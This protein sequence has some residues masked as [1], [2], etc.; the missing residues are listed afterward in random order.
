MIFGSAFISGLVLTYAVIWVTRKYGWVYVPTVNRWS[1]RVVSLHGGIAIALSFL[2]AHLFI[3]DLSYTST[4]FWL[5][6]L[7][8]VML[9][10][11]FLDDL[12]GLM[13]LPKLIVQFLV[14][15]A[16]F[17][18][19]L[20]FNFFDYGILN[21]LISIFWIVGVTN[22]VNLLDNMDGASPGVSLISLLSI[23][24][25]CFSTDPSLA[26]ISLGLAGSL[27]GF[28]CFNFHPSKIFMG[29]T[30]SLFLGTLISLALMKLSQGL[31]LQ[32]GEFLNLPQSLLIP[33]LLVVV[34]ILDTSFVTINRKLNGYPVSK[35]DRG[36]IAH[37]LVYLFNSEKGAVSCL[38]L[39]QV[40]ALFIITTQSFVLLYPML[41][42][43]ILSLILLTFA[44][45]QYVWPEKKYENFST[46]LSRVGLLDTEFLWKPWT[47]LTSSL[48]RIREFKPRRQERDS[49]LS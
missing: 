25:I 3:G 48:N 4:E 44:T 37:R 35:G 29:D 27:L 32:G 33:A 24:Y 17:Y 9:S 2:I 30:G 47:W 45:N 8:L 13:P 23:A 22:A 49:S 21:F 12:Y 10:V 34:P 20:C 16:A 46:T 43:T 40:T 11:G 26:I 39:L 19:G 31:A 15:A 7:S 18:S 36:H 5:I 38:Y 1:K 28:L 14:S 6:G 42:I 41:V